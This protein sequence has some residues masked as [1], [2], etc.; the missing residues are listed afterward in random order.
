V[1]SQRT[2]LGFT[3]DYVYAWS[4]LPVLLIGTLIVAAIASLVPARRIGRLEIVEALRFD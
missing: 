2:A 4:L 1:V 3:I